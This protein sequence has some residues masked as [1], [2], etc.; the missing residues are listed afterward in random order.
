MVYENICM[1]TI[2]CQQSVFQRYHSE[3]HLWEFTHKMA[4]KDSWHWNY[5]TM[6][7]YAEYA[8]YASHAVISRVAIDVEKLLRRRHRRDVS[9][10]QSN[11][12]GVSCKR[13]KRQTV[14]ASR[15]LPYLNV[16]RCQRQRRETESTCSWSFQLPCGTGVSQRVKKSMATL[17]RHDG[18]A[19]TTHRR[20]AVI[21]SWIF[22]PRGIVRP[23][24]HFH[25]VQAWYCRWA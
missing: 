22:L 11:N 23:Y 8:V 13:F 21:S 2:A 6:S 24:H 10:H 1:I 19:C 4:A 9:T 16:H 3:K 15:G 7:Q 25:C 5:V 14:D 18:K 17:H 12:F 20:Y